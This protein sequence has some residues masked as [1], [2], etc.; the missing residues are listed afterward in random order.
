MKTGKVTSLERTGPNTAVVVRGV[1][2][3][4]M[5]P[6]QHVRNGKNVW[7]VVKKHWVSRTHVS[8]LLHS[9][10]GVLPSIGCVLELLTDSGNEELGAPVTMKSAELEPNVETVA[11]I[12]V[13]PV[14]DVEIP[15]S[16]K[17]CDCDGCNFGPTHTGVWASRDE[18]TLKSQ[19]S[20]ALTDP[21]LSVTV[22][23]EKTE[24]VEEKTEVIE[25][26][27]EVKTEVIEEVVPETKTEETVTEETEE[28]APETKDTEE[29]STEEV[30]T[31]QTAPEAEVAAEETE[32]TEEDVAP[33]TDETSEVAAP[34]TEEVPVAGDQ[35]SNK[36]G[37]NNKKNKKNK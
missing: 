19:V 24:V 12:P 6:G 13:E 37:K 4:G 14:T 20:P 28:V 9:Q 32:K 22:I 36:G 5:E 17:K 3:R 27:T 21:D 11:D 7:T 18:D 8:F 16:G 29:V 31:E 23:E 34:S 35:T 33:P 30:S 2:L 10:S 15:F 26:K 1:E 25:E